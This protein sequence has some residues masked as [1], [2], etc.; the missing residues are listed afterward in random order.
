VININ[1]VS[2]LTVR[3]YLLITDKGIERVRIVKRR[4]LKSYYHSVAVKYHHKTGWTH[5]CRFDELSSED[6]EIYLDGHKL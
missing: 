5:L 6:G 1:G 2:S 3:M 4:T